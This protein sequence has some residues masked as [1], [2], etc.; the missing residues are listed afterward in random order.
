MQSSL[1]E[2]LLL[3]R[4]RLFVAHLI[5]ARKQRKIDERAM[6]LARRLRIR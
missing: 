1:R 6:V 2:Q 3:R 5:E 4:H